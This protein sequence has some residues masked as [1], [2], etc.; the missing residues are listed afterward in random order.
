[1]TTKNIWGERNADPSDMPWSLGPNDF[2]APLAVAMASEYKNEKGPN[3]RIVVVGSWSF[4]RNAELEN[5]DHVSML[6]NSLWWLQGQEESIGVRDTEDIT[7]NVNFDTR[8]KVRSTFTWIFLG[9]VPGSAFI[10]GIAA[11]IIRRK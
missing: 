6:H 7:R 2:E 10:V 4:L 8:G 5:L 11:F 9:A 1:M 3:G